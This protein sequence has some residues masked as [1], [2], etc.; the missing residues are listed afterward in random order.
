MGSQTGRQ[1]VS[2]PINLSP[3]NR[4][5]GSVDTFEQFDDQAPKLAK[6][7]QK[8]VEKDR[9]SIS[10]SMA[11]RQAAQKSLTSREIALMPTGFFEVRSAAWKSQLTIEAG[12][13][14]AMPINYCVRCIFIRLKCVVRIASPTQPQAYLSY[15]FPTIQPHHE[16][17]V[18][19]KHPRFDTTRTRFFLTHTCTCDGALII[20]STTTT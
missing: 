13:N 6:V 3:P 12:L 11:R 1:N 4:N 20:Y 2:C 10:E 5:M 9:A 7:G 15:G 16:N 18:R 14:T 17:E 8:A 19:T